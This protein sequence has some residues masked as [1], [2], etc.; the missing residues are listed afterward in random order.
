[1]TA[2]ESERFEY[3]STLGRGGMGVVFEAFDRA[4]GMRVAIKTLKRLDATSVMR[5]KNEFRIVRDLSHPNLVN[6]F[7]LVSD[8]DEWI[9]SMEV[10]EG[11]DF[12]TYVRN[13]RPPSP[14]REGRL[15]HVDELID[16]D[17]FENVLQQ[18]VRGVIALH[19]AG[20][21]HHDLKPSNVR[22]TPG[23]R[24]VIMDFGISI[25]ISDD[26]DSSRKALGTPAFMA[27][28]Q[29]TSNPAT[30]ALDWYAVGV[31]MYFALTGRLPFAG[32]RDRILS[33]KL[34][35]NAQPVGNYVRGIPPELARLTT[36]LLSRNPSRRPSGRD[37]LS[38]IGDREHR[39]PVQETARF[40]GRE[41]ELHLLETAVHEVDA[42]NFR[43][44]EIAGPSG[45]GK[46]RLAEEF[47]RRMGTRPGRFRPIVLNGRCHDR[48]SLPFKAF[49]AVFDQVAS[50]LSR[51]DASRVHAVLPDATDL[52]ARLFPVLRQV[53]AF[54]RAPLVPVSD[55]VALR[56]RAFAAVAT[57][58]ENLASTNPVVLIIDDIQWADD[59]SLDLLGEIES[60]RRPNG[61]LLVTLRRLDTS[62]APASRETAAF[63][64]AIDRIT[65]KPLTAT[66]ENA[67]VRSLC[68]PQ[69]AAQ[70][71][72]TLVTQCEGSPLLITEL[73]RFAAAH[74]EADQILAVKTV[75]EVFAARL[76]RLG[77]IEKSVV[78]LLCVAGEFLPRTVLAAAS[79]L[80]LADIDRCLSGLKAASLL[81]V[82]D[83]ARDHAFELSH[84]KF[85]SAALLALSAEDIR[86][87]HERIALA[88]EAWP[89][90][91]PASIANHWVAA[92]VPKHA[93]GYLLEAA[94]A[95][96]RA[97]AFD[98]A[99]AMY[100]SALG[101]FPPGEPSEIREIELE[102][103]AALE[104]AG[105]HHEAA[106]LLYR[107]RGDDFDEEGTRLSLR[108][109]ANLL[110][111]GDVA[112]GIRSLRDGLARVGVSLPATPRES[113]NVIGRGVV[114]RWAARPKKAAQPG[115]DIAPDT[116]TERAT[117][118]LRVEALHT[119]ALT[120]STID[121]L[122]GAAAY[123]LYLNHARA[124]G[125]P[126]WLCR[127]AALG[128]G[129]QGVTGRRDFTEQAREV[130][131]TA[132]ALND[133]YALALA[134][135][136]AGTMAFL[137]GSYRAALDYLATAMHSFGGGHLGAVA[138]ELTT[139]R[140]FRELALLRSG[141]LAAFCVAVDE[142]LA[143]TER[144]RDAY[145]GNLH[146]CEPAA[147]R[148]VIADDLDAGHALVAR[149]LEGWSDEAP[150]LAHVN[151]RNANVV[152]A[153]Y[154]GD[155][156]SAQALIDSVP[157]SHRMLR[158][159]VPHIGLMSI[160]YSGRAAGMRG[161]WR[162]VERAARRAERSR[163][164][165]GA[166]AAALLRAVAFAGRGDRDGARAHASRAVDLYS[167]AGAGHLDAVSRIV[168]GALQRNSDGDWMADRAII[169]LREQ[170]VAAPE[171]LVRMFAPGF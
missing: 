30:A 114:A 163:H 135:L 8:R 118:A 138:W 123:E 64:S 170:N 57:L 133:E 142:S 80:S 98:R 58:L 4:R 10:V 165:L 157:T 22:V 107:L 126:V 116:N 44:I 93:Q 38:V 2:L 151:E 21:V 83:S 43:A 40:V 18:L 78:E 47:V 51:E 68:S 162:G 73:A 109:A 56:A 20:I 153:L 161:D 166:A 85:A 81:R 122:R 61:L 50:L 131:A 45:I 140:Y 48:E 160:E 65:M 13:G 49:D 14:P 120:L 102:Y 147:W 25:Q 6:L 72:A 39:A 27:P 15:P 119:A 159:A 144:Q 99:R 145:A 54:G 52:V 69:S 16:A 117:L 94:R 168:F 169:W 97:L 71:S 41:R 152:L 37:L 24:L 103:A 3:I 63:G 17:R 31:M 128:F 29:V 95:A 60:T 90:A 12:I 141:K 106:A 101:M 158:L 66:E 154:R 134:S 28:E 92:G 23:G 36:K 77:S 105:A 150:L 53:P 91:Q 164:A 75:E 84:D 35:S 108:A 121:I 89:H 113:I 19:D 79:A 125:D 1:M 96:T 7:E 70:I 62:E 46:S 171:K 67:L 82:T 156:T 74:T 111:G 137:R 136:S 155:G 124:L 167:V 104:N 115:D 11:E 112:N 33:E 87:A 59:D 55:P 127:S 129:Y 86:A 149:G 132:R 5:L 143:E 26:L 88:L 130:L 100:R 148:A 139:T 146:R 32:P 9:L 76:E 34:A 110:R 42:G